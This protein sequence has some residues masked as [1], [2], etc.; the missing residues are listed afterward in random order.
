MTIKSESVKPAR[1]QLAT[2]REKLIGHLSM[3]LFAFLI[4]WSFSLG[5]LAVPYI[6]SAP[7]NAIRFVGATVLI[8][9]VATILLPE[10]PRLPS[11]PWRFL[12]LGSLMAT[13]FVTMFVALK[14]TD[15]IST[16]AVFT[17]GP[18][19]ATVFGYFVL[20]QRP[21]LL[22]LVSLLFA[23]AGSVWVIFKGD[24]DA[25]LAFEVGRGELIFLVG[26][27][28]HA[29]Y[30]PMVRRLNRGEP[31]L[32]FTF[33]TLAATMVWIAGYGVAE[34]LRTDWTNLPAIV[35]WVIAYLAI[36]TTAGTFFLVQFASLR[37]PASKVLSYV[38]L[39]PVFI[40]IQEGLLGH[41]WAGLPIMAGALVTVLGLLV[42]AFSSD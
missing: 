27:A 10:K 37:L 35:W 41:G 5:A 3:V 34:I 8:G 1:S 26:C 15:P 38:Y 20:K 32:L 6:E 16:G 7:L 2:G 18:L 30:A 23:G 24:L 25:I 21:S 36:F 22:I 31:V 9:I 19:M 42:L 13:Y 33:W 39:T 28:G 17:L 14:I 40:I 11:A 12:V 4:A 29:L